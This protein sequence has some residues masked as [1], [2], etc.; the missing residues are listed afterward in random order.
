[1]LP[2]ALALV[3][4]LF[5]GSQIAFIGW[6]GPR[7]LASVIFAMLALEEIAGDAAGQAVAVIGLTVLLSV[8]AHGLTGKPFAR[9][10]A[11]K[12]PATTPR[13]AS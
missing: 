1:M 10:T 6:F 5:P 13:C 9:C 7:G 8:F 11:R 3:G 2:V 4:S 12:P